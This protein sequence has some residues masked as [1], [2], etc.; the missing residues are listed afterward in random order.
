M[1]IIKVEGDKNH[2]NKITFDN[3][4]IFYLD[5]DICVDN[6]IFEGMEIS[7]SQLKKLYDSSEYQRAKSR[8]MWLLG[9]RDYTEKILF[10]KLIGAGFQKEICASVL[11]RLVELELVNDRRFAE[12]YAQKCM[13]SNISKRETVMKLWIKGIGKELAFEVLEEIEVNESESLKNLIKNKYAQK[14]KAQNGSQK[15]FA[16]LVR[17]GFSYSDVR[18]AMK[19]YIENCEFCEE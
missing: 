8:A 17:K 16:T 9:K 4:K 10:E 19:E 14:L 1:F 6:G 13:D 5:K 18:Q 2:L 12:R 11:A 7:D 3:N 15:V